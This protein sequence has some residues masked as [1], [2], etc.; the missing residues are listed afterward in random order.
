M[1][2]IKGFKRLLLNLPPHHL[3][4]FSSWPYG[5]SRNK[6]PLIRPAISGL[7][8]QRGDRLTCH[9]PFKEKKYLAILSGQIFAMIPKTEFVGAFLG[10]KFPN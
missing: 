1:G 2:I 9:K 10:G 4:W 8:R 7:V 5:K 3:L 6:K